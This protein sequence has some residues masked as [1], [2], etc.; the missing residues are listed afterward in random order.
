[1]KKILKI[2]QKA[3]KSLSYF[4]SN[5]CNEDEFLKKKFRKKK[6]ICIDAGCNLG[7][8]IDLLNKNLIIKKIYIF[9]PSKICFQFLK[10]KYKKKNIYIFNNALSN[11]KK[12]LNFYEKELISQSSLIKNKKNKIFKN[13][14]NKSI[15]KINCISLDQF[16]KNNN[17]KEIYDII[18]I[19]CEGEDFNILKGAEKILKNNLVSLI[20]IEIDF[21]KNNFYKIINFFDKFNYK[22]ITITKMKFNKY[23]NIDHIDAYFEKNK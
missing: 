23:Q 5:S 2:Y 15:Y 16:Y 3:E 7:T 19:D 22:L 10:E 4:L 17:Y 21:E 20:K 14:K 6:I 13:L 9:E 12:R 11:N 8:Y 18:K 1:M